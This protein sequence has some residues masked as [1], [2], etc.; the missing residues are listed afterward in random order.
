MSALSCVV[1]AV[2][3]SGAYL[4]EPGFAG[5]VRQPHP[6][7]APA[8]DEPHLQSCGIERN[9]PSFATPGFSLRRPGAVLCVDRVMFLGRPPGLEPV[10]VSTRARSATPPATGFSRKDWQLAPAL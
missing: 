4:K 10:R 8:L 2:V 9:R 7:S 3:I 5:D 6:C 1:H